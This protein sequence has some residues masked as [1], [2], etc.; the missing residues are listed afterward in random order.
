[1]MCAVTKHADL[2]GFVRVSRRAGGTVVGMAWRPRRRVRPDYDEKIGL[3]G[4]ADPEDAFSKL[5]NLPVVP[6]ESDPQEDDDS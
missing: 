2:A 3:P 4:I 1:M 5:L 6:E